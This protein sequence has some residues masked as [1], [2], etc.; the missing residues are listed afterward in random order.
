MDRK[1]IFQQLGE[2]SRPDVIAL[3]EYVDSLGSKLRK[4]YEKRLFMSLDECSIPFFVVDRKEESNEGR[5]PQLDLADIINVDNNTVIL[6][7]PG[8]GKTVL[9]LKLAEEYS[10]LFD[11]TGKVPVHIDLS[12][13]HGQ[14]LQK[15]IEDSINVIGLSE[16][17]SKEMLNDGKF[18]F[19]LDGLDETVVHYNNLVKEINSFSGS[20]GHNQ[21]IVSCRVNEYKGLQGF[22]ELEIQK[23]TGKQ[24]EKFLVRDLDNNKLFDKYNKEAAKLSSVKFCGRLADYKYYN[25]DQVVARVLTL[26]EKLN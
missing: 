24:L 15:L 19:L 6:G 17:Q 20:L 16:V 5:K 10:E 18:V 25:M 8:E 3:D 1:Q 14:G 23:V 9:M 7:E 2:A 26:F 13:Y 11:E 22:R 12:N 4:R 21:F